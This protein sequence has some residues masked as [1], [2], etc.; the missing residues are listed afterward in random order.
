[1]SRPAPSRSLE[2]HH[3]ERLPLGTFYKNIVD[4]TE[5]NAWWID[6]SIPASRS[7]VRRALETLDLPNTR[8]L[9]TRVFWSEPLGSILDEAPGQ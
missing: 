2:P 1:M 8:L 9:L 4:R 6:R 7:G 5:L 3:I